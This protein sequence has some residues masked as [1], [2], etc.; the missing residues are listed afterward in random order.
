[1]T[2]HSLISSSTQCKYSLLHLSH[3]T[4]VLKPS[5]IPSPPLSPSKPFPCYLQ[6][7]KPYSSHIILSIH[8]ITI[9]SISW[10]LLEYLLDINIKINQASVWLTRHIWININMVK[11]IH[12]SLYPLYFGLTLNTHFDLYIH[13]SSLIKPSSLSSF[14]CSWKASHYRDKSK[15]INS[16]LFCHL[17]NMLAFSW[18]YDIPQHRG[19]SIDFICIVVFRLS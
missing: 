18:C 5:L 6:L 2:P 9:S 19:H 17:P 4:S 8:W 11:P 1:M 16:C 7:I 10:S 15:N 3:D 12:G 14:S 13:T